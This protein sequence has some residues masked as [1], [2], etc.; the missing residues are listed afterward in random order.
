M[1][2]TPSLPTGRPWPLA[3]QLY[4]F[5]YTV[6][7][8]CAARKVVLLRLRGFVVSQALVRNLRTQIPGGGGGG[9]SGAHLGR[10]P[11]VVQ[12]RCA[13]VPPQVAL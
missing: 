11:R 8:P 3:C 13:V 4:N 6:E 1:S 7:T 5:L 9:Y 2:A 12:R 10:A